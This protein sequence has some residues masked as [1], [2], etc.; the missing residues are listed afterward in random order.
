MRRIVISVGLLGIGAAGCACNGDDGDGDQT[1]TDG[2]TQTADCDDGVDVQFAAAP[3]AGAGN[4]TFTGAAGDAWVEHRLADG[5]EDSWIAGPVVDGSSGTAPVWGLRVGSEHVIRV[6]LE[7][8]ER[9][10]CAISVQTDPPPA[11]TPAFTPNDEAAWATDKACEGSESGYVLLSYLGDGKS[12]VGIVDRE[13]K[14]VWALANDPEQPWG[15][16][17]TLIGRVRAG[18]DG[19]S[20]VWNVAHEKREDD[21]A[22]IIRVSMDGSE[23]TR[24]R[25]LNGHHDFVELPD[26]TMAWL[27]YDFRDLTVDG[28]G[29]NV[30]VA[31]DTIYEAP[32][33]ATSD[34]TPTEVFNMFDD[35]P[36]G[37]YNSG[38]EMAREGYFLPGY[39]EFSHGNSLAHLPGSD[40]YLASFRWLDTINKIDRAS[41]M[42]WQFGGA[43]ATVVDLA[44]DFTGDESTLF[45]H[46]HFS[47][48]WE[49]AT[50]THVVMMDNYDLD[51]PS[52]LA[53]YALD[54]SAMTYERTWFHQGDKFETLLGDVTRMPIPGCD[55]VLVAYSSQGRIVEMTRDGEIVWDMG[56]GLGN[57]VARVTFLPTLVDFGEY[58][59]WN[60]E[61]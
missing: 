12:G 25:T 41:G 33:G 14:Y 48:V 46:P 45:N 30:P 44:S 18:R 53:E 8:G 50:G 39:H 34:T 19:A 54:E 38:R 60:Q 52:R 61:L 13:G 1:D 24:T 49:D 11:G 28:I 37:I 27:G 55:N 20:L 10:S 5:P 56:Y 36:Y 59:Y 6:M 35:Y 3:A 16:A 58:A 4:V 51:P 57:V 2:V 15:A 21:L 47:D 29:E 32:E 23:V 7:G 22:E 40:T 42:L 26:G 31:A 9:A 17:D 43:S